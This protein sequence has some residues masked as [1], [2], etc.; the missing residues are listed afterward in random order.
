MKKYLIFFLVILFVFSFYIPVSQ[1]IYLGRKVSNYIPDPI[2]QSLKFIYLFNF[3]TTVERMNNDY[4]VAF[5]P[6]T[7]NEKIDFKKINLKFLKE[8]EG[9]YLEAK[10]SLRKTFFLEIFQ[11]DLYV[12][13]EDGYIYFS[14]IRD[15]LNKKNNFVEVKSNLNS[16]IENQYTFKKILDFEINEN[17]IY[18][19]K[20][21][22]DKNCFY[23]LV[24]FAVLNQ[25]FLTFKNVFSTINLECAKEIIQAGKIEILENQILLTT[26]ADML[27]GKNESDSK[28]QDNTSVYG[29]LLSINLENNSFEIFNKGHRNSLGLLVDQNLI[30]STENGPRGGDEINIELKGENYGWDQASYGEKYDHQ[31]TY[32]D[33]ENEGYKEPLFV[34]IP[35]IGI[36][37]IIK[38]DNSFSD[39]WKNNYLIGSLKG[40]HLLRIKLNNK[41]SKVLFV[42]KIFIGERIRDLAYDNS[43]KSVL[44]ALED[45]GSIGI[46][47]NVLNK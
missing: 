10:K 36:S 41:A 31:Y 26:S 47:R 4:N 24:D 15:I 11:R 39:K 28:P 7:Q 6:N 19:S 20:V 29:K 25:Q 3:N 35:S 8:A 46:F 40:N 2:Y 22:R 27:S 13:S 43:T 38:L 12:L 44:L 1:K 17:K 32:L 5:L 23:M 34:F 45:T 37:E 42:E 21:I 18:V 14:D 30:L 9:G 33:H 16:N